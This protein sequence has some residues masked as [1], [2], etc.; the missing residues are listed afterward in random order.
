MLFNACAQ[1]RNERALKIKNSFL[2]QMSK[3]FNSTNHVV[4]SFLNILIKFRD[5]SSAENVFVQMKTKEIITCGIIMQEGKVGYVGKALNIFDHVEKPN[6]MIYTAMINSFGLNGMGHEAVDLYR[7]M[8]IDI[9]DEVTYICILNACSHSGLIDEAH[10]IYNNIKVKTERITTAMVDC[11]SRMFMFDEA[12]QLI[13][14]FELSH[15]PGFA[16]Y[17]ALLSSARNHR[18]FI[19]SEKVLDR[20]KKLFPKNK[21]GLIAGSVLLCNTYSSVGEDEQAKEARLK[22]LHQIGKNK[23]VGITWTAPKGEVVRFKTH[24][25]SHPQSKEIYVEIARMSVELKEN[26]HQYD[27][28]WITRE[29]NDDESIESIL[30]SHSEKLAIAFNFIQQAIPNVIQVTRNLRICGDCHS[31]VKLIAKLRQRPIIIRDTNRFHHFD[32]SGQ[33]S[34]QDHF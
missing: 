26:G 2:N 22:Q 23:I 13:D 20:M 3:L 28:R 10:S 16:M 21:Q 15:P 14:N 25:N 32:T 5:I 12:Q 1:L 18:N 17:M 24:D 7:R 34:C 31:A 8:P 11:M 33:C 27:S 9:H 29:I 4:N 30:C 6:K 19:L